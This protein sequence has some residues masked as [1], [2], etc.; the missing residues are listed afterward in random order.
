M[1]TKAAKTT[2]RE[3]PTLLERIANNDQTAA[4]ECVRT[5][6][7]WIWAVALKYSDSNE[8]AEQMTMS[9]FQDIWKFAHRFKP[10]GLDEKVFVSLITR[11]HVRAKADP[12]KTEFGADNRFF[13]S[14]R[15]YSESSNS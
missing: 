5:H 9:I 10:S 6:G 12:E 11:R 7:N 4:E 13:E 3:S 14:Y 15:K 2:A 8:A 1:F